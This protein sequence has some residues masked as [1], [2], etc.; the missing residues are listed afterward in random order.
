MC[1]I[2]IQM[3][4]R[5]RVILLAALLSIALAGVT[6]GQYDTPSS[7][8]LVLHSYNTDFQWTRDLDAG[9]RDVLQRD[10]SGYA[11]V[12][13]EYLDGKFHSD[14]AHL[15][16]FARHLS[17]KYR[18]QQF[19]VLIITDNLALDFVREY[20]DELFGEVPTVFAGIN[21]YEPALIAGLS[22]ITGIPEEVSIEE[23]LR[24]V[25]DFFPAGRLIVLGDGTLTYRRNEAVL[26]R[27]LER[28]DDDRPVEIYPEVSLEQVERLAGGIQSTDA[29]FLASSVLETD[30]TVADFHR[31]GTIVS[32]LMPVPVFVMWDFFMGTGVAGGYLVSGR[33]QGQAA[34][35]IARRILAG[36]SVDT[37]PVQ[38]STPRSWIFDMDPLRNAGIDQSRLPERS[39]LYNEE[40]SFWSEYNSEVSWVAALVM[41]LGTLVALLIESRRNRAVAAR[42]LQESLSEKEIL[43]KEIHHRVKNNLQVISSILNMQSSFISDEQSLNYFKDCEIRVQSMALV[44]EQ[45]YQS[46]S[47]ARIHLPSY[48]EELMSSLYSAM[49]GASG[50]VTVHREIADLSL[51]LD[52]AIPVGLVVNELI[53]NAIKYAYP[54]QAMRP[55]EISLHVVQSASE[56]QIC[57]RDWGIG[58]DRDAHHSDSLGLQLVEALTSQLHGAIRFERG[59]PGL[60]VRIQFPLLEVA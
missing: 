18:E 47:L 6:F 1:Y 55:G 31:A 21:D 33:E 9:I 51:D 42:H 49:N 8:V 11:V 5:L 20:R 34:A 43:L 25:F 13:S 44:H 3:R 10:P 19:D 17:D 48:L 36:T 4:I 30:G 7:R 23:T 24:L 53:S 52:Q 29:V 2:L 26:R 32:D 56:V 60:L 54:D 35:E 57:V 12:S 41:V 46:D 28:I 45:L 38:S 40:P 16:S 58:L 27:A 59:D 37:I 14:Q 39:T 22:Q 50:D 15:D